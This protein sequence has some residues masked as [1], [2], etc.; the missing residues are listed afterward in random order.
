MIMNRLYLYSL[1]F[2]CFMPCLFASGM[3]KKQMHQGIASLKANRT[4]AIEAV[5]SLCPQTRQKQRR[6]YA[7]KPITDS[8]IANTFLN[9]PKSQRAKHFHE[10]VVKF[11]NNPHA[12]GFTK[13]GTVQSGETTEPKD[14]YEI[15]AEDEAEEIFKMVQKYNKVSHQLKIVRSKKFDPI[16]YDK[17]KEQIT[18]LSPQI[19]IIGQQIRSALNLPSGS[20]VG[21]LDLAK[22][23]ALIAQKNS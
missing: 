2:I 1:S 7:E 4:T 9:R 22:I 13:L 3:D 20:P 15:A 23:K 18:S 10:R 16:T 11:R 12:N 17:K 5:T 14:I 6:N 21:L 8:E 19:T